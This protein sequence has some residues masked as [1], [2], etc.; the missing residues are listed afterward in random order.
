MADND[1]FAWTAAAS[2]EVRIQVEGATPAV[3]PAPE[4]ASPALSL[5]GLAA[6][7]AGSGMARRRRAGVQ[8]TVSVKLA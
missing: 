7:L 3:H 8:R 1:P 5:A 6:A 2:H 4:P